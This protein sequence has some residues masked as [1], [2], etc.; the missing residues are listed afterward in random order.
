MDSL[1]LAKASY[2]VMVRMIEQGYLTRLNDQMKKGLYDS[3][4]LLIAGVNSEKDLK[5]RFDQIMAQFAHDVEKI[6]PDLTEELLE[7][8][9]R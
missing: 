3:E 5:A 2:L 6:D 7:K 8:L 9:N 1:T 4:K